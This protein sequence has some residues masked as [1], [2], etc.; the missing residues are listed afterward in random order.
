MTRIHV[1]IFAGSTFLASAALADPPT[2]SRLGDRTKGNMAMST[3]ESA[4]AAQEMANCLVAKRASSAQKFLLARSEAETNE[5][6]IALMRSVGCSMA[7]PTSEM[8]DTRLVTFPHDVLRGALAEALL[9]KERDAAAALPAL[10]LARDYARPWFAQ[11][12]RNV[13]VDEMGSCVADTNPGGVISLLSVRVYAK[14]EGPLFS[15]LMPNLA[16]CLR[17]NAKLQ[18]NRPSL[19]AALAEALYQRIHGAPNTQP[20]DT[21]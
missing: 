19:R 9:R 21:K 17:A 11:T 13:A 6:N 8:S 10:P 20:A 5:A 14:D 12:T 7:M 16:Q 1:L 4:F 3:E 2:G 18:A 15:A